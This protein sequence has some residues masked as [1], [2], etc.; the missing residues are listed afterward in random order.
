MTP[1]EKNLLERTYKLTE[2]NNEILRG[3]RRAQ[4]WGRATKIA[5]W[6]IIAIFTVV[7]YYAIMPYLNQLMDV[8]RGIQGGDANS[9]SPSAMERLGGFNF[10]GWG[11]KPVDPNN[12]ENSR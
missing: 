12:L 5:Y 10:S 4:R 7:S 1:E 9:D 11:S 6:L 8:Y 3:M 2:E